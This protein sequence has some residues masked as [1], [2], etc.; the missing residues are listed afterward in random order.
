M[1][2]DRSLSHADIVFHLRNVR[3]YG[4]AIPP[5]ALISAAA[6]SAWERSRE[7]M[8]TRAPLLGK[9]ARYALPD[10]LAGPG[11]NDRAPF[12]RCQHIHPIGFE[13]GPIITLIRRG[14]LQGWQRVAAIPGRAAGRPG[15]SRLSDHATRLKA[16]NQ[17][18]LSPMV[19]T[20]WGFVRGTTWKNEESRRK[21][22][23]TAQGQ[24]LL[25]RLS[26][27]RSVFRPAYQAWMTF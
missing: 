23:L 8:R 11:H 27:N 7:A 19:A 21:Q 1:P 15:S 17:I 26:R 5:P 14:E 16:G 22:R 13:D 10:S 12:D 9:D 24:P 2:F 25:L 6:A 18:P 20:R 3:G 4:L